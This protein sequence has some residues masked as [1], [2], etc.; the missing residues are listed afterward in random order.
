[1]I[2][3]LDANS[4]EV[5]SQYDSNGDVAASVTEYCNGTVR[6]VGFHPEADCTWCDYSQTYGSEE[7]L[8]RDVIDCNQTFSDPNPNNPYE[9]G[10]DLITYIL[11]RK[12]TEKRVY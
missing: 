12:Y 8:T 7:I 2:T 10:H 5:L 11:Q 1:M 3:S 6:L 4:D 9:I